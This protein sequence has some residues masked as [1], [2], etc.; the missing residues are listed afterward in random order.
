MLDFM[1]LAAY[2]LR[3][4]EPPLEKNGTAL[5]IG[6][7]RSGE[8]GL[9]FQ[10]R[11]ALQMHLFEPSPTYFESLKSSL[12]GLPGFTLHNYGL[13]AYTRRGFL[14]LHGTA[15]RV[16]DSSEERR[17]STSHIHNMYKYIYIFVGI[18]IHN[19]IYTVHSGIYICINISTNIFDTSSRDLRT[20]KVKEDTEAVL[21]RSAAEAIP[22]VL[23]KSRQ[24][25]VELLHV[26]CEGCA[27]W[28]MAWQ[29]SSRMK[30][31]KV[32]KQDS[33]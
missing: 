20:P 30:G 33:L 22:E 3:P 2:R 27:T 21:I 9:E 26:N 14:R 18:S 5:Y 11:F 17:V 19:I 28:R 29:N 32:L 1:R 25:G 16:V 10:R 31:E 8:D 12:Q 15:S 7:H 24:R 4:F 23:Q 6:A 13:G